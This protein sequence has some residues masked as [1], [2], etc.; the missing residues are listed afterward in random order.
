MQLK[1]QIEEFFR[2]YSTEFFKIWI[3]SIKKNSNRFSNTNYGIF[4]MLYNILTCWHMFIGRKLTF[5][6]ILFILWNIFIS[7]S[8]PCD[9]KTRNNF[10]IQKTLLLAK[11]NFFLFK[12][13]CNWTYLDIK[14]CNLGKLSS[15]SSVSLHKIKLFLKFFLAS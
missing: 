8:V 6:S 5:K 2:S 10:F 4:Q 15:G 1:K 11:R 12:E 9:I 3:A 7:W 14:A 13:I